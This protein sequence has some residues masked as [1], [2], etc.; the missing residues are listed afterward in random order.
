MPDSSDYTPNFQS[1]LAKHFA[2][3]LKEKRAS[4]YRYGIE[5]RYLEKIDHFLFQ[6]GHD[7]NNLPKYLVELWIAKHGHENHKTHYNRVTVLRQFTKYISRQGLPAYA[8][9]P[10]CARRGHD[11]FA[12]YIFSA[13]EIKRFLAEV[14]QILPSPKSP[15]RHIVMP[16]LFRLLIFCGLR[17]SEA[18]S[19]C[20]KDVNLETGV[21]TIR[22]T[23]FGKDRL[24]PMTSSITDRLRVFAERLGV[25]NG[26]MPFF[27]SLKERKYYEGTIYHI[28]RD[29]LIQIKVEHRGRGLGP[30]LHD[31]RHTFA[32][33][34][35]LGWYREGA[36]L[37][38][39]LL[40][41]ATYLG[42]RGMSGTQRYLHLVP[43]L[44]PEVT[45]LIERKVGHI[46]P[47]KEL[48]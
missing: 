34:R 31:F 16:E 42:H 39:K 43:E 35:L 1:V 12:P 10:D 18:L 7:S 27:P 36:D 33:H 40:I 3:H 26:E 45:M 44:L 29:I 13:A 23:K 32:V 46:I 20:V 19:L 11:S 47:G 22:N 41:L 8:P 9:P 14:D 30:R 24:V 48:L 15:R 17:I 4:G 28:F 2:G 37:N 21:L 6:K 38:T 5:A 25:R